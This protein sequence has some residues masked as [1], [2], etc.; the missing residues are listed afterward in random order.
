MG[1]LLTRGY[2]PDDAEAIATLLNTIETAAGGHPCYT[3]EEV[4]VFNATAVKEPE[5]ETRLLFDEAGTLAAAAIV[6]TPPAGGFRVDLFGG[7]LPA[8]RG[9]GIGRELLSW[10]LERAAEL[11]RAV[12]P[13]AEWEVEVGVLVDDDSANRLFKRL[14]LQPARYFFEMVAS[15]IDPPTA[16]LPPGVRSVP[17]TPELEQALY[18]AHM[19]AFGDHW[20]YQRRDFDSWAPFTVQAA[21]F[22]PDLSRLVFDGDELAGYLLAYD[23]PGPERCYIGQVGT[24]KPWRR[25]GLAGAMLA[26]VLAAAGAA[27]RSSA[28]LSVDAASPTGAVGVYERAGFDVAYRTVAYRKRIA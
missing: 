14:G 12:A 6:S 24:R 3:S 9:R 2:R 28:S 10:Q 5:L 25:R 8:W 17:Y 21:A 19:E 7:V 4:A 1:Q 16:Q 15:T 22:R 26:Q 23:D 11:H 20:G 27:G 18:E 13:E